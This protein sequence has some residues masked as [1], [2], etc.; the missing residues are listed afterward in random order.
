MKRNVELLQ[1]TMQHIKDHPK[2]HRQGMVMDY[3][4]TAG[5]FI[6]WA[7]LLSGWSVQR[8]RFAPMVE[9][10]AELLGLTQIETMILFDAENTMPMLEL[11]VKD[12]VNGD[13]LRGIVD[14]EI[15]A[16]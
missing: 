1:R 9:C 16:K 3:C 13:K 10:G 7:A 4:G 6:G 11:M 14:Y 2:Q 8:V 15:E 5:C 12:L